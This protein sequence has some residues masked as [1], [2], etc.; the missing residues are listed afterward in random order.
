METKAAARWIWGGEEDFVGRHMRFRK[1]FTLSAA[2]R[3]APFRITADTR[4][5]LHVN[6]R[7]VLDGPAR[8]YP[9]T[10]A[11]DETDLAPYLRVGENVL[12]VH[13]LSFG[14]ST[15]QNIFRARAGLFVEGRVVGE[16]GSRTE[17][18]TTVDWRVKPADVYRRHAARYTVQ[19][20]FQ[21][22]LDL[23]LEEDGDW[24]TPAFDD[25]AWERA[26]PLGPE[27]CLPWSEPEARDIPF[28]ETTP[29]APCRL[30]GAWEGRNASGFAEADNIAALVAGEKRTAVDVSRFAALRSP[31]PVGTAG[32]EGT[33]A[34]AAPPVLAPPA[35]RDGFI[36]LLFDFGEVLYGQPVLKVGEAAGDEIFDLAYGEKLCGG[37]MLVPVDERVRGGRADRLLCRP[38]EN[39][40]HAFQP[41]G[42]RYL[43]LTARR[44]RKP[45]LLRGLGVET[46]RYPVSE[47]G[48]FA[49]SDPLLE[50]IWATGV[51]TLRACMSDVYMDCPTREQAGWVGDARL[52]ALTNFYVFG[53]AALYRRMLKLTARSL[54]PNGLLYG[55]VPCERP[56]CVLPD[57]ALHWIAGLDEYFFYTGEVEPLREHRETLGKVLGF[58]ARHAGERG[59]LGPTPGC[60]L[61]MD[62]APGLDRGGLSATFNLLYLQALSAATRI[63]LALSDSGLANHCRQAATT[64]AERI[65]AVFGTSAGNLLVESVDLRTGEPAD[66]VSQHAGALAVLENLLPGPG[67]EAR[68]ALTELLTDFSKSTDKSPRPGPIHANLFFRYFVH[69]ALVRVGQA[70][71]ALADIRRTWGEMLERGAVTWWEVVSPARES[72]CCH[73]WSAHPSMFISRY[74]LGV[75]PAEAGWKRFRF[76]PKCFDLT[77][78]RGRVPT[79][80]GAIEVE[81]ERDGAG[82]GR[83][84]KIVVPEGLKAEYRPPTGDDRRL[85]AAGKH[86]WEEKPT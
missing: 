34:A 30:V 61:F 14:L 76:A 38:G 71:E 35:E 15:F 22:H 57:Y 60:W 52:E 51:K 75:S 59:L 37:E 1:S 25:G 85:L 63:G 13:V 42:F 24:T 44:L 20:G 41:R 54:L 12:A 49:C 27:G 36:A 67:K 8:G 17:I 79:P 23:R 7:P 74:V 81:W 78:A 26:Q 64:L 11:V 6:G 62:W 18:A 9:R 31:P 5:R 4:Y 46:L 10:Q 66:V 33:V 83:K 82:K 43:L 48:E 29:A 55:V 70:D 68:A 21:E 69:E 16:D 77:R 32:G 84:L 40:F 56:N 80:A 86:E 19:T 47:A 73:A 53:D 3:H 72:S 50:R 2:P 45:L 65:K 58:F 39:C 28:L